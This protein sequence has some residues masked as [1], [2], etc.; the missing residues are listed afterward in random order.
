MV[1]RELNWT[2]LISTRLV[3]IASE[4]LDLN[5]WSH[6]VRGRNAPFQTRSLQPHK[7][8]RTAVSQE[9]SEKPGGAGFPSSTVLAGQQ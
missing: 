5:L 4:C 3:R 7:E 1:L 8:F 2:Q 9:Y 6:V